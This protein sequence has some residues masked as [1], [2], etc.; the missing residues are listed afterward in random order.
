VFIVEVYDPERLQRTLEWTVSQV[1]GLIQ[2]QGGSGVEL[3]TETAGGRTFHRIASLDTGLGVEYVF[4]DGYL[5]AA[6]TRPVLD[7][8]I[9]TR[10]SGVTLAHSPRFQELLPA[11]GRV[12]FSAAVYQHLG[13]VLG[14]LSRFARTITDPR[15]QQIAQAL[16]Q[17]SGASL[18]LAYGERDRIVIVGATED[19]LFGSSLGALLSLEGMMGMQQ[20]LTRT[21]GD[22]ADDDSGS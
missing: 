19:G 16:S 18:T 1:H 6:L 20:V 14:P 5:L 2:D 9:Q 17:D 7:R 12:N 15:E 10:Q 8:A 21:I 4:D 11:D 22:A 13:P 3:Q